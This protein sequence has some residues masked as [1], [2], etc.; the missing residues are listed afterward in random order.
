[1]STTTKTSVAIVGA[2][3]SG[4]L[5]SQLLAR[6]GIDSVVVEQ[7]SREYVASR[8]RAGLL[9]PGTVELL[10]EAGV[11]E[12]LRREGLRHGGFD[13]VFDDHIHRID[14]QGLAGREVTVY[15]QTEVQA[16][17]AHARVDSGGDVRFE[18]SDVAV[19]GFDGTHPSVTFAWK[20]QSH[21]VQADFLAGC[22]G[23]HG[24]C[25]ASVPKS[26]I[27]NFERV[28]PFGWLGLLADVPPLAHE[29]AYIN[30]ERGFALCSMR[31]PSR[32]RYYLQCSLD[33]RV[34]EWSDDR[35][36]E[37]LSRRL[38]AEHRGRLTTGPSIEKS[39]APLRSFVAEPMRFGRL[40]L[41]GDAAHIV[42]P[43]GAKGLNLAASDVR[44]LF[45]GLVEH[46]R[47]KRDTLLD[48]Y[49]RA[50]L[51][52]VWKATR[53]SWWFTTLMHRFPDD[54]IGRRLQVAELDYVRGSQAA[55]TSI[56][57]NYVG[58]P[59]SAGY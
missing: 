48:D 22:D 36:W 33:D 13:M 19:S 7:R 56:A 51:L 49:S 53:F 50:A 52:R 14:L 30:N 40:F 6:S 8:I 5:L 54:E 21:T 10:A 41:V 1:M 55:C 27:R 45:R 42:P 39:I 11:D 4:L 34:E 57:E 18:C 38:P 43:T 12:R 15:G 44:L 9:E 31:S 59:F 58:L 26:A 20:G 23:Y 46:Y 47:S 37:E 2:G 3:P 16:D 32:S 17:L 28:Y 24:I 29:L 25:R 35:F